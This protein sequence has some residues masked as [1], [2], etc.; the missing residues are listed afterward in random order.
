M[1]ITPPPQTFEQSSGDDSVVMD[2]DSRGLEMLT[3]KR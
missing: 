2:S 1:L 3:V